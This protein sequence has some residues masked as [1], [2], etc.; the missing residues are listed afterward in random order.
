MIHSK[1]SYVPLAWDT[2]GASHLLVAHAGGG[3]ALLRLLD[4]GRYASITVRYAGEP[5]DNADYA[6]RL[7]RA[8][9]EA[10]QYFD[11]VE[12]MLDALRADLATSRMG[13]R[14]YLAGS[15][16]FLWRATGIA[17][18]AGLCADEIRREQ[19]GSRARAVYCV[20]CKNIEPQVTTN[21][22]T[23]PGCARTLMVRDHYSARLAAYMGFQVDAEAPGAIPAV[24][25]LYA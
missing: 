6:A 11:S 10:F 1:P 22:L 5:F 16:R 25:T 8:A 9:P 19:A 12:A 20:H 21:I 14:L 23:C 3:E 4:S 17:T 15:E 18:A 13:L 2:E 24:E 7:A